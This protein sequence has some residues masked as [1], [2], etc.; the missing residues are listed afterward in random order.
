MGFLQLCLQTVANSAPI[1]SDLKEHI[2]NMFQN[3]AALLNKP[4]PPPPPQQQMM[5]SASMRPIGGNR[6][7][8]N[9][10]DPT[11]TPVGG[12]L[13][14]TPRSFMPPGGASGGIEPLVGLTSQVICCDLCWFLPRL[15]KSSS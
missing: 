15:T 12:P 5:P 9:I 1:H 7:L 10:G 13:R 8:G 14:Q 4:R 6:S 3:S 2:V 11:A